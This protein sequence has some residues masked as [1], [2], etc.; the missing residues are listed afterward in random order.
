[1]FS[2]VSSQC[3]GYQTARGRIFKGAETVEQRLRRTRKRVFCEF[4]SMFAVRKPSSKLHYPRGL[5][6]SKNHT[7]Y[8]M[9]RL[10]IYP[11]T[12]GPA[13]PRGTGMKLQ[14]YL[15]PTAPRQPLMKICARLRTPSRRL[16][17][18]TSLVYPYSLKFFIEFTRRG[19]L[20]VINLLAS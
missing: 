18:A 20:K 9:S 5:S 4:L 17:T 8:K 15:A 3:P 6:Y 2:R 16:R 7:Y 19:F 10:N 14:L 11:E 12:L 13:G 1:M